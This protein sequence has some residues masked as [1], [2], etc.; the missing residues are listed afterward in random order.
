[1]IEY[2][3]YLNVPTRV[4]I[5]IIGLFF[6]IQ[7]IGELMEFT[8]KVVPEW[9]KIRKFFNRRKREREIL[10]KVPQALEEVNNTLMELK[11]YYNADNIRLNNEWIKSVNDRL[12]N[13]EESIKEFD[14]KLDKNNADTL[15]LLVESK[16]DRVINFARIVVDENKPITREEFKRIFKLYEEYEK[17]I[18]ENNLTN[19]EIEIAHQIITEA[20]EDHLKNHSFVEDIR[21]YSV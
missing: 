9:V 15:S 6:I 8:G 7:V 10:H 20:Y 5:S 16:R 21:G 3:E 2:V 19:G 1:M 17:M 11:S 14:R 18:A 4:A 13:N 12:T